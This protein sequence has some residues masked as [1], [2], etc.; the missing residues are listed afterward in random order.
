M[1]INSLYTFDRFKT[2]C[3]YENSNFID[4]HKYLK[5]SLGVEY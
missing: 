2:K 3:I 5:E 1:N 4:G